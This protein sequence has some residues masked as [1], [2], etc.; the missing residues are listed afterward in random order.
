MARFSPL[1]PLLVTAVSL[2]LPALAQQQPPPPRP[3]TLSAAERESLDGLK[4]ELTARLKRLSPEAARRPDASVF[5]RTAE[6][7]DRLDLYVNRGH[8]A[9]VRRG[10]EIGLARCAELESGRTP[11]AERPGR[12]LRGFVSKID[13]TV[14]PYGVV[15]PAG[16]DPQRAEPYPVEIFLHG[17]GPTEVTF[18]QENEPAP[19]SSAARAPE[20]PHLELHPFGRGN[21][22]WRWSGET[23][24]FEALDD[25]LKQYP[26]DP[27]RIM[28]RGF[29]MG[30]H[31]AWHLGLHH[32]GR[33]SAVSPGAGFSDTRRYLKLT[34]PQPRY[35]E[36][37]WHIYDA[38]D[39]ARNLV[40]VPFIAYGGDKDPQ[41][42][43]A[44]N[45]KEL[46]EA[47]GLSLN[48]IVGPDTEHRYHPESLREIKRQLASHRNHPAPAAVDFTT[49]TLKYPQCDWVTLDALEEHYRRARVA[50]RIE[51]D[52]VVV[53]TE[54]VA[55]LTLD[56]L[57]ERVKRAEIDGRRVRV[58][59]GK[60]FRARKSGRDWSFTE[61]LPDGLRKRPGLQGPID[62]AFTARFLAVRGT[63]TPWHRQVQE[64]ADRE[65]L[66]FQD[67]FRFGFRGE[68]Q[69]KDDRDAFWLDWKESNLVLFGDPGSNALI[70][71]ILPDLPIDWTRKGLR[72][73]GVRYSPEHVPVLV[74][75]NP[76]NPERYVVINSG[77]TWQR[78]DLL[79]SNAYLTPKLPD[80]AVL[81][82]GAERAEVAAAG[83]FD[84]RWRMRRER[85][86]DSD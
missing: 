9:T 56:P 15:L 6:L 1:V 39:Y 53:T 32:P 72:V 40:N 80:W 73:N 12:S 70:K 50:A 18:L 7:A 19:G 81:R 13:G 48:L 28:L 46:A 34:E 74:F 14:Q 61:S 77:H 16:F 86:R 85:K 10:L 76:L 25:F 8:V 4:A 82:P 45:I 26:V 21:N 38:V 52:R 41:L 63:G 43:A 64:Y 33:W 17:R 60:T 58:P 49:W 20:Q 71:K 23:D 75:P 59:E 29:S 22:G 83:Y 37:A 24:V 2:V 27:S 84:E 42:Q 68:V 67:D 11:W 44:L 55:A 69:V 35:Q 57:P 47:E 36:Q 5:L 66:R 3:Y 51:G 62:D 78:R 65:L 30:G 79:A 31:G 54:N